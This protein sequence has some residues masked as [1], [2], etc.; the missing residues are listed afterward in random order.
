MN[1]AEH[2]LTKLYEAELEEAFGRGLEVLA[3]EPLL[4]NEA[5]EKVEESFSVIFLI[6]IVMGMPMLLK[7]IVKAFAFVYRSLQKL[8]KKKPS[9]PEFVETLLKFTDKWH[10]AYVKVLQKVLKYAG[11]FKSSGLKD[12]VKQK[13]ATEVLFYTIILGLAVY[14]GVGAADAI[15]KAVKGS[16]ASHGHVAALETVLTGLKSNEVKSFIQNIKG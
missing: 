4:E 1:R 7:V 11:V 16:L 15:I 2:S 6:N 12:P 8:F 14:S 10:D 9:T 5:P 3:W 13:M